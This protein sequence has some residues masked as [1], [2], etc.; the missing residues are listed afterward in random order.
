MS[1]TIHTATIQVDVSQALS[2]IE[3]L[4]GMI[5]EIAQRVHEGAMR[6][7][8]SSEEAG[9]KSVQASERARNA[10]D[11]LK[12]EIKESKEA[13][14][15]LGQE[16]NEA[17]DHLNKMGD[18]GASAGG[19]I[20]SSLHTIELTSIIQQVQMIA[21]GLG[22]LATPAINFEQSMADLSAITGSVGDELEDLSK[23]ARRV[24]VESGLGASESARAFA[25]LAGQIDVP[26][27]Q[28]KLLQE[29]T[30]LLAQA[31][32]LP[33][34]E[35]S[36]AL[37][38]TINQFGLEASEASRIVN[39][40]SAGSRAGGSEVVDLAES[41]KVA[42]AAANSA[43]VSVEETAGALEV[44]AQNN[45][46]G[47]EAGT[48]M[49][50]MLIAMQTRLGIDISKTGFV[51]GLE[52]IKKHLNSMGSETE[53]ATFL[54]KTFGRE[55][56]VAAQFLLK[57]SEAVRKMT[58]EVTGSNAAIEQ[59]NIRNATWAH[60]LEVMRARMDELKISI[61]EATGG[62]L[63][64]MAGLGEQLVPLAQL[65]PLLGAVKNAFSGISSALS[66]SPLGKYALIFGAI[67]GAVYL[68]YQ[69]S[70]T[71]RKACAELWQ[72]VQE[73]AGA[74]MESLKPALESIIN[75]VREIMPTLN[76]LI[77]ALGEL[78]GKA[79]RSLMPV[80]RTI[81]DLFARLL[82]P[83]IR[84]I[85]ALMPLVDLI[86]RMLIPILDSLGKAIESLEPIFEL[87]GW[88]ITNFVIKPLEVAI[89]LVA[90]LISWLGDLF[91]V[92]PPTD[93]IEETTRAIDDQTRAINDNR[94]AREQA[95]GEQPRWHGAGGSWGDDT[96]TPTHTPAPSHTATPT[97]HIPRRG[98]EG[99]SSSDEKKVYNL[100]TIEGLSNNISKIQEQINKSNKQDAIAL[101]KKANEYQKMLDKLKESIEVGA[102]VLK[103]I[104]ATDIIDKN[105]GKKGQTDIWGR[106]KKQQNK[107]K[108]EDKKRLDEIVNTS[109]DALYNGVKKTI[110]K[111]RKEWDKYVKGVQQSVNN[112]SN[113]AGILG[114]VLGNLGDL[115]ESSMLKSAS[116]WLG[117]GANVASV[118]KDA[119][120]NLLSLFN[121]NLMVS[122]S[123]AGKSQAGIPIVGP[124]M[125][126]TSIAS[127]IGALTAVPK[128]NA[129]ADGGI[130][131]GPTLSLTGEYAGASNNPEVIAPLNK[132]RDLIKPQ[133]GAGGGQVTFKIRGRELVGIL[134]KEGTIRKLS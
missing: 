29:Q 106:D 64:W 2:G 58:G 52:I 6:W 79:I 17:G 69:H 99:S 83:I 82:P 116:A 67:A 111:T 41:F 122:A 14:E 46:K 1:D 55:N 119:L 97:L 118:I 87:W 73:S 113:L 128:V 101:Q 129:F 112:V 60:R 45:T 44:L 8:D 51:G 74:L 75:A 98:K 34:E 22:E 103:P 12:D 132:L 36:N 89:G 70:E 86:I 28:L 105:G 77:V 16:A 18:K 123:E 62:M 76:K 127:I 133:E 48:A 117:W 110:D 131:Y 20:A 100:T 80:I 71:F 49:R 66:G 19:R 11:K 78:L 95:G 96:S 120:P 4:G 92:D 91:T 109:P 13:T 7:A 47:A 130:V 24:G 65:T 93:K 25:I 107:D 115:T 134:S 42:G 33:L 59:A 72:V 21:Q 61:N 39:V 56:I 57:N 90:D 84:I 126:I 88:W 114:G 50:N 9:N 40:L 85:E 26:L 124:I 102:K 104:S 3:R 38:G 5:S 121:A 35:A 43:G 31:G 125:A 30:I 68:A 54:A 53:R 81:I 108:E 15:N 27:E 32:A 63:P 23:T 10:Q 37:A 94:N